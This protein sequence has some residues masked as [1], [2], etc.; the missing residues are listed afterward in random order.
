M[1]LRGLGG[2]WLARPSGLRFAPL[3]NGDYVKLAGRAAFLGFTHLSIAHSANSIVSPQGICTEPLP[4][5]AATVLLQ[6][7]FLVYFLKFYQ[8]GPGANWSYFLFSFGLVWGPHL[9]VLI[10]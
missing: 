9:V 6:M 3:F 7:L 10:G 4:L 8:K 1:L 2:K 5:E